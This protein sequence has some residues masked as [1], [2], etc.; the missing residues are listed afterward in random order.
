MRKQFGDIVIEGDLPAGDIRSIKNTANGLAVAIAPARPFVTVQM[1]NEEGQA[2][3]LSPAA[4]GV[5]VDCAWGMNTPDALACRVKFQNDHPVWIVRHIR[6]TIPAYVSLAADG[7][8]Y[9]MLPAGAGV[10]VKNPAA[11]LFVRRKTET[12]AWKDRVLE[13]LEEGLGFCDA[14]TG[15]PVSAVDLHYDNPSMMWMDYYAAPGGIYLASHDPGFE[16]TIVRVGARAC[17]PGVILGIE[18]CFN[19]R[20][21]AWE[22]TFVLGLHAGDWHRGA[23]IYRQFLEEA[24][25]QPVRPPVYIRQAPGLVCHYDFKWQNGDINHHFA[26][27][28]E[29]YRESRARGFKSLLVAGWNRNGFDNTY[30]DF[31][32]DPD[33]GTEAEMFE[34]IQ[35]IHR[36]GGRIFFYNNAFSFDQAHPDYPRQGRDWALKNADGGTRDRVWGHRNFSGMC[37]SAPGWRTKV[38]ANIRY[39]LE[40]AGA[41]GV[42]ID[43]LSVTP[44]VCYDPRHPHRQSWVLNNVALIREIRAELGSRYQDKI[45]LFSEHLKDAVVTV[46][47]SQLVH[48]CWGKGIKYACPAMFRYTLPTALLIDQVQTKPWSGTP[49]TVEEKHVQDRIGML[50]VNGM[51]FWVYDHVLCNPRVRAAFDQAVRLRTQFAEFFSDGR[52][53][54]DILFLDLPAGVCAKSYAAA[55][56]RRLVAVYNTTGRNCALPWRRPVKGRLQ[57][58]D[59]FGRLAREWAVSPT[60]TLPVGASLFSTAVINQP[61]E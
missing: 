4:A 49:C 27:L 55:D 44:R 32:P 23:D 28:P 19:R 3:E 39:L 61:V 13:V 47:D 6:F 5:Q 2:V 34:G 21:T 20:L 53:E 9:L 43:Q 56:G 48:T 50:F 26:D 12:A 25:V 11:E 42:Y 36:L 29:L 35:A 38:K 41:D 15:R 37:N 46:L 33:L 16:S 60:D 30:P 7:R 14:D 22:G 54:D 10:K 8:D 59:G 58:Y 40:Q 1:E 17:Q 51:F 52:F 24:G 18:K 31:R 45:F 57:V